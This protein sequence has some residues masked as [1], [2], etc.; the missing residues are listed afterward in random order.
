MCPY[1]GNVGK[2]KGTP[3]PYPKC[4]AAAAPWRTRQFKEKTNAE[5]PPQADPTCFSP[6]AGFGKQ[7]LTDAG[8]GEEGP[9]PDGRGSLK[10]YVASACHHLCGSEADFGCRQGYQRRMLMGAAAA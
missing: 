4:V 5:G 3:C 2:D 6:I 7:G 8:V 10:R 1:P 9:L